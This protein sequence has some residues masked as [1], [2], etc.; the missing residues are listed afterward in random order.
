MTDRASEAPTG[1]RIRRAAAADRPAV[2]RFLTEHWGAPIVVSRGALHAADELPALIAEAEGEPA[3]AGLLT[4]R[5]HDDACEIV[6]LDAVP[7]GRGVGTAL[8]TELVRQLGADRIRRLWLITTN[9][10]LAALRF[11]QR[12]GFVLAALHPRAIEISRRLKPTIPPVGEGGIP[13]RDE[14][15]LERML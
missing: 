8:V 2:A 6:S 15:E 7:A 9:D 13:I 10:N 14:L 12:R 3:W 11:Y 5:V 4:Y 1:V